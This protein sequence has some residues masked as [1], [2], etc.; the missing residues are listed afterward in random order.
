MIDLHN[1]W[2]HRWLSPKAIANNSPIQGIGIFAI[3]KISKGEQ[4]SVLGGVIVHIN[5]ID[6][7]RQIMGHIGLQIDDQFFMVPTTRDELPIKGTVNHSCSPNAGLS[8]SVVFI[9]I[10][11]IEPGEECTFDYATSETYFP[12]FGCHCVSA[13]CR[14]TITQDDWK[15]P[16]LQQKL[17]QYYSP[18]LRAKL[19]RHNN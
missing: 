15:I 12:S 9:A 3:E 14:K 10:R 7:Y 8:S 5:D 6:A 19:N 1:Q 4:I 11:D 16:E 17:G 18:Y 2:P 13:N